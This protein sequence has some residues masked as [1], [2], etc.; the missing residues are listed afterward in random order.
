MSNSVHVVNKIRATVHTDCHEI[1][2]GDGTGTTQHCEYLVYLTVPKAGGDGILLGVSETPEAAE[3]IASA[4][5]SV[6]GLAHTHA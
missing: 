2:A 5:N 3:A 6:F 1:V 4:L